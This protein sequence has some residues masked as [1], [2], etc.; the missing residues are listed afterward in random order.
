MDSGEGRNTNHARDLTK[1]WN[2]ALDKHSPFLIERAFKASN[3]VR[4]L[5]VVVDVP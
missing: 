3:D 4:H 1:K 5:N 2:G